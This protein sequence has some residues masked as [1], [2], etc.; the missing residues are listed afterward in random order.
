[1]KKVKDF[2]EAEAIITAV[3]YGL[4][5]QEDEWYEQLLRVE[6]IAEVELEDLTESDWEYVRTVIANIVYDME[7]YSEDE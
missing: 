5:E 2:D 3:L 1:M 7:N 6:R 4:K